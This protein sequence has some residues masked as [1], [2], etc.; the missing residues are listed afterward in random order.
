MLETE[1]GRGR[2][3]PWGGG[4]NLHSETGREGGGRAEG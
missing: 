1:R 2:I 3:W 4:I